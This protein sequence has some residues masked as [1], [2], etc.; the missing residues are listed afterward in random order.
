MAVACLWAVSDNSIFICTA[1]GDRRLKKIPVHT[2]RSPGYTHTHTTLGSV[3]RTQDS[4]A[5]A[6]TVEACSSSRCC[7]CLSS[8]WYLVAGR[9]S[10]FN[11]VRRAASRAASQAAAAVWCRCWLYTRRHEKI[12]TCLFFYISIA[13]SPVMC[14]MIRVVRLTLNCW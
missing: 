12:V 3:Y 2:Q 14:A 4:T 10:A 7:P 6:R 5:G 9:T 1:A 8:P 13:L 11:S